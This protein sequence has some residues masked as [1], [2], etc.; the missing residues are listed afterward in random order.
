MAIAV[1]WTGVEGPKISGCIVVEHLFEVEYQRTA[2]IST[3][4]YERILWTD[5]SI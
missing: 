4:E 3:E 5:L 1:S 2:S